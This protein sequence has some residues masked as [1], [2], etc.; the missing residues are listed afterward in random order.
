MS[1][2]CPSALWCCL[3]ITALLG[4]CVYPTESHR[5]KHD[6]SAHSDFQSRVGHMLLDIVKR[7]VTSVRG[8][9][10]ALSL[11]SPSIS[12]EEGGVGSS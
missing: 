10:S 8:P 2:F 11:L 1:S 5:H 3:T 12:L 9:L 6:V 4:T 7:A